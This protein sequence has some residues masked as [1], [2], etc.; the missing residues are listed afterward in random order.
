MTLCK[1]VSYL[2][3]LQSDMEKCFHFF[4]DYVVLLETRSTQKETV[5]LPLSTKISHGFSKS[6]NF[7]AL[8]IWVH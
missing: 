2:Q 6:W 8:W 5:E 3:N 1:F 7:P 4:A